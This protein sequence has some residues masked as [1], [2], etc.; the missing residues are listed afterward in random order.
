M[1]NKRKYNK[2]TG[3]NYEYDTAF[4][5]SPEQVKRREG[6]NKARRIMEK[7]GKVHKGQMADIDHE[8]FNTLDNSPSNIHVMD[9]SANRAKK[10]PHL[11]KKKP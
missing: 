5:S 2:S 6:R 11:R 8:N 10:P 1:T 4:E 7:K 9:R 3:R